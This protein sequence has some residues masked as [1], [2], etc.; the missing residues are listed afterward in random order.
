MNKVHLLEVIGL[1]QR[2]QESV[3]AVLVEGT[4]NELVEISYRVS[5]C[6]RSVLDD[7]RIPARIQVT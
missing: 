4:V 7:V 3:G 1:V 6:Q 5:L 2:L